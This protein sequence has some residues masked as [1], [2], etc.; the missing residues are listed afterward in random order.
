MLQLATTGSSA[1]VDRDEI[2]AS[3]ARSRHPP[4]QVHVV[5]G[6]PQPPDSLAATIHARLGWNASVAEDGAIIALPS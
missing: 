6:E 1:H 2:S 5:H 4:R 3:L